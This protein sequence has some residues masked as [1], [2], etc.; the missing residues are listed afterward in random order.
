MLHLP[1][2]YVRW[3]VALP[4]LLSYAPQLSCKQSMQCVLQVYVGG[5]HADIVSIII[6]SEHLDDK[7]EVTSSMSIM[8]PSLVSLSPA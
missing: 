2:P 4:H 7:R 5:I 3:G 8:R 1:I 6:N